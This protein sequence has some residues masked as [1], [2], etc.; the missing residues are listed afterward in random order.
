MTIMNHFCKIFILLLAFFLIATLTPIRLADA[1]SVTY[2]Y[3]DKNGNIHFTDSAESIPEQYRDQIKVLKEPKYPETKPAP[4]EEETRKIKEGAEKKKEEQAKALQEKAEQEEKL[5][6][7]KEIEERISDLQQQIIAKR[8]EQGSLRTT[9]M[10]YDRIKLNQLND[11]I[12]ALENEI[13]ALRQ[14]LASK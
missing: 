5:K 14:E 2:K 9:W 6:A 10:V 1:Q 12:A 13:V 8:E 4:A 3:V 7:R 11:E